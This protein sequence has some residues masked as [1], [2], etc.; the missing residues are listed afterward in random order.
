MSRNSDNTLIYYPV[1]T[2]DVAKVTR[3]GS[4]DV[5]TLCGDN[6]M[7][8]CWSRYKPVHL[9]N[10]IDTTAQIDTTT[11]MWKSSATWWK[12]QQQDCGIVP[13]LLR[14]VS[15]I[16]SYCDGTMNGW[17]YVKP[18]GGINSPYRLIDFLGYY[19]LAEVPIQNVRVSPLITTNKASGELSL[20]SQLVQASTYQLALHEIGDVSQCYL[21][22]YGKLTTSSTIERWKANTTPISAVDGDAFDLST[23]NWTAGKWLVYPFLTSVQGDSSDN[24][25]VGERYSIPFTEPIEVTILNNY[26]TVFISNFTIDFS[27]PMYRQDGVVGYK[28]TATITINNASLSSVTVGSSTRP[29]S[30]MTRFSDKAYSDAMVVGEASGTLPNLTIPAQTIGYT[31]TIT[32][33]VSVDAYESGAKLWVTYQTSD[34]RVTDSAELTIN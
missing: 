33:V 9:P 25:L 13:K 24:Q 19:H 15:E 20:I 17:V 30:Y 26:I 34:E 22:L 29:N 11:M 31:T 18:S 1:N 21:G 7:I 27:N 5:G 16:T 6:N 28:V 3:K 4:G 14:S 23:T 8:N 12:G 32:A 2:W 10:V